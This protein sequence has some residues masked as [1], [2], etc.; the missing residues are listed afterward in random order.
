MESDAKSETGTASD[1]PKYLHWTIVV[2]LFLIL[3][4][5]FMK[6]LCPDYPPPAY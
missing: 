6:Y 1:K 5:L 3:S 2:T 4:Y